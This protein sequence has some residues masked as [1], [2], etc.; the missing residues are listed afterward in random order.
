MQLSWQVGCWQ[1][2][3]RT[4]KADDSKPN[5]DHQY[6][7]GGFDSSLLCSL[8]HCKAREC[9]TIWMWWILI[10]S[11]T[12]MNY[13]AKCACVKGHLASE[14]VRHKRY[15]WLMFASQFLLNE[16]LDLGLW[17]WWACI[18]KKKSYQLKPTPLLVAW[19]LRASTAFSFIWKVWKIWVENGVRKLL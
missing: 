18:Q 19:N 15:F 12:G 5:T 13:P 1:L 8:R 10:P 2:K 9:A 14:A 4:S 16:W 11:W 17:A 3:A 6:T 7:D